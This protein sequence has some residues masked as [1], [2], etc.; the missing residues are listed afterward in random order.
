VYFVNWSCFRQRFLQLSPYE[1]GMILL[2]FMELNRSQFRL[3]ASAEEQSR[4]LS[5]ASYFCVVAGRRQL[6]HTLAKTVKGLQDLRSDIVGGYACGAALRVQLRLTPSCLQVLKLLPGFKDVQRDLDCFTDLEASPKTLD[7]IPFLEWCLQHFVNAQMILGNFQTI[8]TQ[9]LQL[10]RAIFILE[11]L[12]DIFYLDETKL[13]EGQ[14]MQGREFRDSL[15][16]LIRSPMRIF[17]ATQHCIKEWARQPIWSSV[18]MIAVSVYSGPRT[19]VYPPYG[20]IVDVALSQKPIEFIDEWNRLKPHLH[21]IIRDLASAH[22]QGPAQKAA[23]ELITA[24]SI[25]KVI[26]AEMLLFGLAAA[27]LVKL[28]VPCNV[29][30]GVWDEL[31]QVCI[32]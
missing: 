22:Y 14:N 21:S 18:N 10:H 6:E 16:E 26:P 7:F 17:T 4:I 29:D 20:D 25:N 12:R 30:Q 31:S 28:S 3:D 24:S 27:Y 13:F 1:H 19:Q 8:S 5:V 32:S 9:G 23:M 2:D 11:A 15:L